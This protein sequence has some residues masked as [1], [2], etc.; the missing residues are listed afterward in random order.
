MVPYPLEIVQRPEV[1]VILYEAYNLFRIIPMRTEHA[2]DLDP[3]WMGDSIGHWDGDT[4]VVDVTSFN[5]KTRVAGVKHTEAMHV[6]ERYT[7]T[8]YDTIEYRASVEDPNVF[9]APV[10]YAGNLTLHPEWQI[11]EYVCAENNKDY[12]ELRGP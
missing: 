2:E 12:S 3:L 4:L 6:V 8:A 9:A 5:D 10:Q 11:G 1:V 7:R